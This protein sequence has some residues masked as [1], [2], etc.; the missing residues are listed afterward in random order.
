MLF[1]TTVAY[2]EFKSPLLSYLETWQKKED[3][4][5]QPILK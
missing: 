1:T 3:K 5:F 4:L 2:P